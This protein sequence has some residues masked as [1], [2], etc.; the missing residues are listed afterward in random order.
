MSGLYVAPMA[1]T[2]GKLIRKRARKRRAAARKRT[3]STGSAV[4][5][6][7]SSKQRVTKPGSSHTPPL[8]RFVKLVKLRDGKLNP[9]Q[10][11]VKD[12]LDIAFEAMQMRQG[13]RP[14][15]IDGDET[16]TAD[17]SDFA[18]AV[19]AAE[20]AGILDLK[21]LQRHPAAARQS[22][23]E[24]SVNQGETAPGLG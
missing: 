20:K 18:R 6:S 9:K 17:H 21:V 1:D 23:C 2:I 5:T 24:G 13:R 22:R 19:M 3:R 16:F 14:E 12:R 8:P 11:A 15:E 10:V 4:S 7:V